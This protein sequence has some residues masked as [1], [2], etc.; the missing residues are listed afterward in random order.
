MGHCYSRNISTVEDK[1]GDVP[2]GVAQLQNNH[3]TSVPSSPVASG[4]TEANPYTIS[5]FQSP[6]PAGVAP[7]P[8]RTPGRKFKWPFP[9]PSPAKPILAALRRRRGTAPQ[10]RDGPIPEESEEVDDQ[11]RAGETAERLDNNF[12]FSKHFE[13]K[14]ELGKEVGRGH[15]GN[16]CWAKAK[17]GKIKG[18]T[19]AVKIIAKAKMTSAL[20]IEDVRRE[21]KLLKALSGH[22][23]MVKFYDVFEDADNVFLVMEL[24]E[25]GEL[26]DR[27]LARGGRFPEADAKRILVQILSATAFFHLQGVVHRDLKPENFLFTSKNEDAV[28][29]VIDFGLSDFSRF[30]NQRLN[31]VVGSAYYVA[32]EVLHRSYGTEADIWSI[33]V[34][35]YILLCGSRPFYGRTESA[36]FR[37]VLRANPN[38]EDTPWPSISPIAKDFVRRL[39]NKD[40][41]KRMTAAQ[42]LAHPWLRG[43]NP[44]LLLDFSI[45]KLVKSYIRASP[46]RRAAL[47]SLSKAIPEEELVFLKAQF[48]LLEPED[49]GLYATDA[50]I[51]SRLPDILNLLQP[52]AHRKLDFEEFCAAAVSVYQL[53]ALE[54]WEQ[55]ATTA[56]EDFEREGSRAISVQELAEEMSLGPNA[57]PLLKDW[58]RSLDGKLS[59]LGY[60]KFLH[61]VTVRSSSSRPTR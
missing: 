57:H 28:L 15:F 4:S 47:K 6:L 13:G 22:R 41:R 43:E 52:L 54:E 33:G 7:S 32:P 26:L 40:H 23:H 8:A 3:R 51:E 58:I 17:K 20:S 42:A 35:S 14:Y 37:C 56:F 16:T 61:G 59:F 46:F 50:M 9:P 36:I 5:P 44:G 21:V 27:I 31:D 24:C 29:K 1:D 39:L 34:I 18:Q 38:F 53:E 55:I 19:V 45:Y 25:G 11:G 10:P 12:G 49:G 48:M 2:N 30:G 60:K